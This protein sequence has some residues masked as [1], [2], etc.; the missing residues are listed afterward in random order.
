MNLDL[1]LTATPERLRM[2]AC[3]MKQHSPEILAHVSAVAQSRVIRSGVV[4]CPYCGR[5][6]VAAGRGEVRLDPRK[7]LRIHLLQ[8]L[9]CFRL[10]MRDD[11][12]PP[13]TR[14]GE[15]KLIPCNAAGPG[16]DSM[17]AGEGE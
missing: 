9:D 6:F 8:T 12:I 5:S 13:D 10:M 7:A 17:R 3:N 14:K 16:H 4:R 11:G 1:W 2:H 15:P